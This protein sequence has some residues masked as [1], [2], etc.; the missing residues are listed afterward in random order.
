M[1]LTD[2]WRSIPTWLWEQALSIYLLI[3]ATSL[4]ME[5]NKSY[6][7]KNLKQWNTIKYTQKKGFISL[8]I[9]SASIQTL[10]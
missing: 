7:K 1:Y 9:L 2:E 4:N 10:F 3:G 5:I 6:Q 8:A